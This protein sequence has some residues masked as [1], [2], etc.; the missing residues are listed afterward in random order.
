MINSY[1]FNVFGSYD[2][3]FLFIPSI[4]I[5]LLLV[6]FIFRNFFSGVFIYVIKKLIF[7]LDKS[8]RLVNLDYLSPPFQF[9]SFVIFLIIFF[10]IFK[11]SIDTS[12]FIKLIK[13]S[14]L[15]FILL[16]LMMYCTI[17]MNK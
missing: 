8:K 6:S 9:S 12:F 15:I 11:E 10:F 14:C 2:L 1:L 13:S 5:V 7:R 3:I 17:I 4:I 16:I